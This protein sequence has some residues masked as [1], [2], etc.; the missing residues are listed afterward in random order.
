MIV[1]K[2]DTI[3]DIPQVIQIIMVH[4]TEVTAENRWENGVE[5]ET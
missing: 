5:S 1:K 4:P 3:M 2:E